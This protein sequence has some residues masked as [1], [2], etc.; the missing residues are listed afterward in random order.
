MSRY[1]VRIGSAL[2]LLL[3]LAAFTPA[4]ATAASGE[5]AI[6]TFQGKSFV[7]S[8]LVAQ[9]GGRAVA[10]DDPTL[11]SF[12]DVIGATVTWQ[13]DER[14]VLV[15]T[16]EPVVISFAIGDR[17]YDVGPVTENAAFAPFEMDGHAYV[18]F[19][20]LVRALD[21]AAKDGVLQPQLASIDVESNASGSKLIARGGMPLDAR[22]L[23]D[24]PDKLVIAFDGVGSALPTSRTLA[25]GP[26]HR[27]DAQTQGTAAHPR[28]IVSLE[29]A[30]GTTHSAVGTD[31]QRD[32]TIGFNGAP[33]AQPIAAAE[34]AAE[35]SA[36]PQGA[37]T[38]APS[39][40]FE[41]TASGAAQVTGVQTQSQDGSFVVRV[42]IQGNAAYDWHRLRPPD[43]RFWV[44]IHGA[45]LA[46]PP[47][48]QSGDTVVTAVRAHQQSPDTVRIALSLAD[49]ETL[50]VA[51]DANGVTITVKNAVADDTS[52]PRAGS[53]TVGS[54]AGAYTSTAQNDGWKF[55]PRPAAPAHTYVAA[56]P[57]LIIIDPGHGGSDV[58]SYRGDVV[59]KTLALDMSKRVRD[60]LV[61]R[62][63]QVIMTRETDKDVF[64]PNDSAHDELQARDDIGNN[65]GARVFVSIHVNAFI[66]SGPHGATV[67]YYKPID[68]ALAQA[69]DRRI[70]SELSI[71]D[72]GVVKDKLYVVHHANMPA[73]LIETAFLSNPDDRVLLQSPQWRQKMAQAIADGIADY[74]GT[75]PPATISGQ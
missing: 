62:G 64:A 47:S 29:L 46:V 8:H 73:T 52:A 26:V 41:A 10:I 38:P 23:S 3:S 20:E 70:A 6:F 36:E 28:T 54:S 5:R 72:D 35:P 16:A 63:W 71:K 51:P 42:A 57:R 53:G 67:Y 48:D 66:N 60:I 40:Q 19:D 31:D 59:E 37:P 18:P 24:T 69:I 49:F 56:N 33:A 21:F 44:D 13:P 34:P 12:F 22:I 68:L 58:G 30:S 50:D 17:R 27:I 61:A 75:P 39:P 7:F 14:Y 65:N 9:Q 55:S 43:N 1:A 25:Q 11:R 32:F 74:A 45:R 15:T 4:C 2:A